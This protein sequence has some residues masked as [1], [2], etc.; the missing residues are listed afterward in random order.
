MVKK[1][2]ETVE[3]V[4]VVKFPKS[5][6]LKA[7]RLMDYRDILTALL[8]PNVEYSVDEAEDIAKKW[9]KGEVK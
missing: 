8:D 5:E 1:T 7:K 4:E 6:I 3:T 9:L 2:E